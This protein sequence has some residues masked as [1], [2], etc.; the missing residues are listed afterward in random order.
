[1]RAYQIALVEIVASELAKGCPRHLE[2]KFGFALER[3]RSCPKGVWPKAE[4]LANLD[5]E[6]FFRAVRI[7][8]ALELAARPAENSPQ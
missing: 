3:A 4:F 6:L 1:M 2:E 8:G 7:F 5:T